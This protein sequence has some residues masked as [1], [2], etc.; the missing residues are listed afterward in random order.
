[1][2]RFRFHKSDTV[3]GVSVYETREGVESYQGTFSL[4][5]SGWDALSMKLGALNGQEGFIFDQFTG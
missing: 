1:M 3:V 4:S 5:H 2:I